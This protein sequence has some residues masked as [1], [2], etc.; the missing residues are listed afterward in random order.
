[1]REG[2]FMRVRHGLLVAVSLLAFTSPSQAFLLREPASQSEGSVTIAGKK[3]DYKATASRLAVV[4]K[5]GVARGSLFFVAYTKNPPAPAASRPLTFCFNGGPG[6]ASVWLHLGAFGPRRVAMNDDGKGAPSPTKLVE[7]ECSLL[8]LTDLVFIDP[9]STGYSRADD[10][11][12]A[13]LFHGVEED[14]QSVGEFIR[15]YLVKYERTA[16]P[17]YLAGESYGTTRAAGL[18]TYLQNKG[19]LKLNGII[20]VSAVLDFSTVRFDAG[21]DLPYP[22]FLPTYTASAWHHQKLDKAW[23]KDLATVLKESQQFA[24]GEYAAALRK[25]N[26]IG[27]DE[28]NAIAKKLA[29]YT[30]LSEKEALKADLRID[31]TRFRRELLRDTGEAIGRL[32]SR[33]KAKATGGKGGGGDPSNTLLTT[34]YTAAAKEYLP[35]VLGYKTDLKYQL[36]NPGVQ[37]WNYGPAGSNRYVNVAPRLR[38]ALEKDR[39]LRVFVA[40]GYD[41]LA[42]PF[43]ATQYTFARLGPRALSERVTMGYYEAGHMMYTHQPS[44]QQL[45]DDLAKFL[46]PPAAA[47]E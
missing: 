11:K 38:A 6:S 1:L 21:N 25:G 13:K 46:A 31:A 19:G 14:I 12:E 39:A 36:S 47:A 40:N 15:Q 33:V 4:D 41:D 29:K 9:V 20:L 17:L 32:D 30:G 16:S 35:D 37:P 18:A 24:E 23:A 8:D 43:A 3:I 34:H 7:N 28:R 22:L 2:V 45:R 26:L 42:T 5:T 44:R 10:P 27:E